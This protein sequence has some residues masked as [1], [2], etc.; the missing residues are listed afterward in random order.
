MTRLN[1]D[2][3]K[4][5]QQW[6]TIM[7]PQADDNGGTNENKEQSLIDTFTAGIL[8]NA[9]FPNENSY[10]VSTDVGTLIAQKL[11]VGEKIRVGINGL[12]ID[13]KEVDYS[14]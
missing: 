9:L 3:F 10:N 7:K 1:E 4:N 2:A 5:D 13:S 8:D 6:M 14:K 12:S 11:S